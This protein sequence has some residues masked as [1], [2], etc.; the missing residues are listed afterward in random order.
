M[1]LIYVLRAQGFFPNL[2]IITRS[3]HTL[4]DIKMRPAARKITCGVARQPCMLPAVYPISVARWPIAPRFQTSQVH[5]VDLSFFPV[6]ATVKSILTLALRRSEWSVSPTCSA[7]SCQ[8]SLMSDLTVFCYYGHQS[9]TKLRI[10]EFG[11]H[12]YHIP[13]QMETSIIFCRRGKAVFLQI[14]QI[15][16]CISPGS[17]WEDFLVLQYAFFIE[18]FLTSRT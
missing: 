17:K 7:P 2:E 12:G 3:I 4:L 9:N 13:R 1:A 11:G 10:R 14:C 8:A 6:Q 16:H 15:F 5:H 18:L